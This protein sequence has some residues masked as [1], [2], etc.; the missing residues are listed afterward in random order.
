[1]IPLLPS[2]LG[3]IEM[4]VGISPRSGGLLSSWFTESGFGGSV[5]DFS[6]NF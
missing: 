3:V 1:M 4:F 2:L 5:V 6:Q